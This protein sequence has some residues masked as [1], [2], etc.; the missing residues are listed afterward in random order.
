MKKLL[1]LFIITSLFGG[2]LEVDGNLKVSG[3]VVFQ[4][5]SSI[6]TAPMSLPSGVIM[7]FAGQSAPEG[8]M[9]C[10]GQEVNRDTYSDLFMILGDTYGSGDGSSTFNLPDLRGR[11]LLG[12]DNMGGESANRVVNEQADVLGGN[13]GEENHTLT[14]DEMPSHSHSGSMSQSGGG[15]S[16]SG[17]GAHHGNSNNT[18]ESG[19]NQPHNNMPP[20][21]TI[22]YI[23]KL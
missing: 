3:S 16:H 23:I 20:F 4:D 12:I 11:M 1:S 14:E 6:N 17:S 8:W 18:S 22:N 9:L 2:E 13:G 7:P 19:G 21:I 15:G 5:E 10:F